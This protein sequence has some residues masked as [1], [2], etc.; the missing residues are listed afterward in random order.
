MK[1]PYKNPLKKTVE[2]FERQ[3]Q[4]AREDLVEIV[5]NNISRNE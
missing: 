3:L 5:K 1:T 2:M 4:A